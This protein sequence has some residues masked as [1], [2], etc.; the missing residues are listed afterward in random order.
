MRSV[1][2]FILFRDNATTL[3]RALEGLLATCDEVLAV[4]TGSADGSAAVVEAAGVR[5]LAVTWRGF[6]AA[7]AAAARAL[8]HH[9]ALFF[10]DSD[11]WLPEA[12]VAALRGVRVW[13][14]WPEAVALRRRDWVTAGQ[15]RF[16]LRS[17]WRKRWVL[18]S[19]A[20]WTEAQFVH[21]S[22][23]GPLQTRR[24]DAFI[25]HAFLPSLESRA[26]RND[27]YGLLWALREQA[28]QGGPVPVPWTKRP[29]MQQ[30][31]HFLR[32]A[33]LKGA[34]LRGGRAGLA[35]SWLVARYHAD[36]YRWLER[37]AAGEEPE[38]QA[39]VARGDYEAVFRAR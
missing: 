24:L 14:E 6:G 8:S 10:L 15:R 7:R 17:E 28:A 36:K 13:A 32:N 4:D 3:P 1:G 39:A 2:G 26:S 5:R 23:P 16:V 37:L 18:T 19:K 21:E 27:R 25:E 12:S 34:A 30:W 20:S 29:W 31:A 11:E 38:M 35:A 9:D 33:V 22:L